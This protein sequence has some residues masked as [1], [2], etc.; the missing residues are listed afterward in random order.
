[1]NGT[2]TDQLAELVKKLPPDRADALRDDLLSQE[3][4]T[5]TEVAKIL[6]LH[7]D[8]IRRNLR[9]GHLKA[10]RLA[11]RKAHYRIPASELI[12]FMERR[13]P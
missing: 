12:R 2:N 9:S 5:P 6:R 10:I 3:F 7:V 8:T 11:G 1:M 13:Q 4:F